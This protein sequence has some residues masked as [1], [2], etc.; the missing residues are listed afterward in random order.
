MFPVCRFRCSVKLKAS[1]VSRGD[2]SDIMTV[3]GCPMVQREEREG[4]RKRE[5]GRDINTACRLRGT[6]TEDNGS[7]RNGVFMMSLLFVVSSSA[8]H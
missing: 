7:P 4:G 6:E 8:G 3:K 2:Y 5:E 1:Q